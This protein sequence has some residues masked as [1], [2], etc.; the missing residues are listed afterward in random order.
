MDAWM[1]KML[2]CS[3]MITTGEEVTNTF[4]S[5]PQVQPEAQ[6]EAQ[7]KAE[8]QPEAQAEAQT[9]T[10][11]EDKEQEEEP[12]NTDIYELDE[13]EG[14]G[15]GDDEGEEEE[16]EE[17]DIKTVL[18]RYTESEEEYIKQK[19]N[20]MLMLSMAFLGA[21][22]SPS[23]ISVFNTPDSNTYVKNQDPVENNSIYMF[24]YD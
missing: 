6:P 12:E 7:V 20:S 22:I 5:Q 21:A 13:D 19:K 11:P 1:E 2:S 14:D 18:D 3:C 17:N 23:L 16:E 24:K 8:T 4:H 15:D 9:Q 10:E